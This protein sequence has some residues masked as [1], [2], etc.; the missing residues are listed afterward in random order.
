M[1][2]SMS[3]KSRSRAGFIIVA[4][5]LGF[6]FL[7]PLGLFA[8]EL[9]RIQLCQHQL[10]AVTDAAALAAADYLAQSSSAECPDQEALQRAKEHGL[11]YMRR[12]IAA[13]YVLSTALISESVDSDTLKTGAS[14]FDLVY[15]PDKRILRAKAA[16]G[17]EPIFARYLGLSAVTVRAQSS[18]E[19]AGLS[20]DVVIAFDLSRSMGFASKSV[21]IKRTWDPAE[22]KIKYEIRKR[23]NTAT[24]SKETLPAFPNARLDVVPD[25]DFVDFSRADKMK[26]LDG[27][28]P[29][30]KLSAL[31]EAKSGNLENL[32]VFESSKASFSEAAK[33]LKPEKGFQDEYQRL[34]LSATLPLADAK[35]ALK[36]FINEITERRGA[37]I[38]MVTFASSLSRKEQSQTGDVYDSYAT[39]NDFHLPN[40]ELSSNLSKANEAILAIGPSPCF[41]ETNT[42]GALK[43]ATAMLTGAGHRQSVPKSIVLLTDGRP[44]PPG[45][46][47]FT[48]LD[49]AVQAAKQAGTAGIKIYAVG[50]FHSSYSDDELKNGPKALSAI[51]E[52]AGNGSRSY[53]AP[54]LPGLKNVLDSV[55]AG[56]VA[57]VND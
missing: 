17:V 50:F 42:G 35:S 16:L 53:V 40:I 48:G 46:D 11:L 30:A 36:E 44:N 43:E 21:W 7:L 57:L 22:Q 8:F 45:G 33:F 54:D 38:G 31:V 12:N 41:S 32:T 56:S 5:C 27:L 2:M 9:S 34:A 10:R 1:K 14:A 55:A 6:L 15:L 23:L 51:V 29:E 4:A 28:S 24:A 37:H 20:G 19:I 26:V 25:P 39:R 18:A 3:D 52:A 47:Y 13:S 49:E